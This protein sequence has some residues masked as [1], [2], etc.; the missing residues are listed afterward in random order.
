MPH[1]GEQSDM[2]CY[3]VSLHTFVHP[4][5]ALAKGDD[6]KVCIAGRPLD[7]AISDGVKQAPHLAGGLVHVTAN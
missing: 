2:H 7:A 3:S 1:N 4:Q 6:V 5:L